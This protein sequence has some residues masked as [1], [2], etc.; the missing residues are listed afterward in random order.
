MNQEKKKSFLSNKNIIHIIISIAIMAVISI[1]YFYPDAVT[2]NVLQQHD[3]TQGIANGQEAKAFAES[4]G[5]VTRWINSLFSGMPTFQI[6]PSYESTELVSWIGKVYGLGLPAPANLIFMMMIGFFILLMAFNVRWYV[7]LFGAIAYGFSSYFFILIGAGHIWKFATLTYV[8]PTIAGIIWCYRK[9]YVLGGIVAALFA[10]MQIASNHFQMTYYFTFLIAA[11]AIGYLVSAIRQKA[12]KDWAKATGA[13]IVAAILA[14]AANA[15][16]LYSTYKYSKETMRGGHSELTAATAGSTSQGLDKDYITAWSYGID[17]TASLIV[18]NV[19]G[20]A[21]IR[22]EKGNNKFLSLAETPKAV[23]LLN[24]GKISGEEY[25]YL[26]QFPQ[27]FGDQPMTNGPVY[28]GVIVFALFLIGCFAVKGALKWALLV[29]TLLSLLMGWGHNAM[30][31]TDAMI[32]HFPFYNKFRTVASAFVVLELTIPLLA[33]LALNKIF[34]EKDF[35]NH[36]SRLIIGSFAFTAIACL[37]I[38]IAPGMFGGYTIQETQ[39]YIISGIAQQI[40]GLFSAV[41]EIRLDMVKADALRSLLFLVMGFVALLLFFTKKTNA[42]TSG[43]IIATVILVDMYS[44]NKRYI[45]SSSFTSPMPTNEQ[46]IARPADK[47]I[48]QDTAMNYRVFDVNKFSD[49]APSYYHKMIGGYHAAKLT[50][51]QDLID[52]QISKNNTEVLNMLNTKYII[53]DDNRAFE[54]P[55]ALGNAWWVENV[56]FVNTP[57]EEMAY[58]DD[59]VADSSAVADAKFKPILEGAAKAKAD[60]DTIF[61]TTYAPNELNYHAV[62]QNGGVAVFSEVY[63]PWGWKATI[64]GKTAEIARVNYVLRALNVPAGTHHINF[65]FEPDAVITAD[66]I[67]YAAIIIIYLAI[68]AYI[69]TAIIKNRRKSEV[70]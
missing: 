7:A 28:V 17:E 61:E 58:L 21:T 20:G 6:S 2:G 12:V 57:N 29:A 24:S 9:K 36:H 22:P 26:A 53:V 65:K 30:W 49:A 10:T 32:D 15:P 27:Y 48:L 69:V 50:R 63:F 55:D 70:K 18:P 23:E 68:V 38:Y 62:S 39:E 5:E 51:Y 19:K 1:A 46:I 8:P 43:V 41:K 33:A 47:Q 67:A 66:R 25:Q 35:F 60:G 44:V 64:D 56:D 31:F 59:F 13:L 16:N 11:V 3:T 40:P 4:T 52:R 14:V 37:L 42:V 34:T 54:N 45:S